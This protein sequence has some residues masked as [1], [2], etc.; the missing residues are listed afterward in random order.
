MAGN[1]NSGRRG[2]ARHVVDR[3]HECLAAAMLPGAIEAET[4]VHRRTIRKIRA[5]G[6]FSDDRPELTTRPRCGDCGWLLLET[7]CRRCEV[8]RIAMEARRRGTPLATDE[9]LEFATLAATYI[10][11]KTY[12]R[13]AALQKAYAA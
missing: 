12:G 6:H 1:R 7:P 5:H 10:V 4:G 2:L 11:R 3:I 8:E 13:R 9:E